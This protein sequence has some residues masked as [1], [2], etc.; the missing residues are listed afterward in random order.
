[1]QFQSNKGLLTVKEQ[2]FYLK[3]D[4]ER[5]GGRGARERLHWSFI[6]HFEIKAIEHT[7]VHV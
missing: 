4:K 5:R 7:H 6:T 1:M 3:E 2:S